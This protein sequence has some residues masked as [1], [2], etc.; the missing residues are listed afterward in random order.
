MSWNQLYRL[1]SYLRS[2]LWI[3]PFIAI[4]L[5]FITARLLRDLDH[6]LG[7]SFLGF[8]AQGAEAMLQGLITATMSF[9]VFTFG[10]MLVAIQVASG[11]LTPRIIATTLLQDNV[12]R[13]S[14]GLFVF[15][16]LFV[17]AA[18]GRMDTR[19]DQLAVFVAACLGIACIG[20][21]LYLID[22]AAKLLRPITILARVSRQG[23]AVIE[24]VYPETSIGPD[25]PQS[26]RETI[27]PPARTI[28]HQGASQVVLAIRVDTLLTKAEKSN[29]VIEFIPQVGDFVGV[30]EPLF[31]LYGGSAAPIDERDL[32]AAIAFGPERTIEQDPTFAYRIVVDLALKA[33]SPAINDPTTAVLAIDQLHRLLRAAGRRHLRTDEILDKSGNLRVV[34]RTPNWE[35]F[36]HLSVHRDSPLRRQQRSD[37]A[38]LARRHRKSHANPSGTSSSGLGARIGLSRRVNPN[39]FQQCRGF[40]PC[41]HS[42]QPG[43]GGPFWIAKV[44]AARRRGCCRNRAPFQVCLT[45]RRQ[46]FE[47]VIHARIDP[48]ALHARHAAALR[49]LLRR[50]FPSYSM[51]ISATSSADVPQQAL[52]ISRARPKTPNPCSGSK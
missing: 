20:T 2:S 51:S 31:N 28:Y 47:A 50:T 4:P 44:A 6:W 12:V 52:V 49:R 33:L 46:E 26:G 40:G 48:P 8:S 7:W 37:C 38:P 39:P 42:R 19:V 36:V 30:D 45:G 9:V 11:Q 3:V 34:L 5:E 25:E 24:S 23:L 21:L 43:L 35:D 15:A 1:R 14:V 17:V 29:G 22:Y 13:Y 16:F 18:A 10:S 41:P 32:R 27:G